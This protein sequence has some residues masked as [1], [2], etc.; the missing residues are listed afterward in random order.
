MTN[1]VFVVKGETDS[2]S[3][4]EWCRDVPQV[5]DSKCQLRSQSC[6]F[7]A[8]CVHVQGLWSATALA[9]GKAVGRKGME[10]RVGRKFQSI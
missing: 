7:D 5:S 4:S 6:Q 3:G 9:K 10:L 8:M 1:V 2:S